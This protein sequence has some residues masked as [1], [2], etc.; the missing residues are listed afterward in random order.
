MGAPEIWCDTRQQKGK[1]V[2]VDGWFEKHGVPHS[3]RKL[4]FGDYM[5]EGSNISI[6]TKQSMD[7]LAGN[8]GKDHARFVRECE[9]A[10]NAGYRLIILVERKPKLNSPIEL[11][12]W[13]PVAC[14]MCRACN[15]LESKGCL[16]HRSKPMQGSTALKIMQ[17]IERK[18]GTR[19]EFCTRNDT[20][21]RICEL[22]GIDYD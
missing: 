8:L 14:H 16:K 6:D 15:P 1:H 17:T 2:N 20:A 4:D 21:Q 12:K 19:F 3:Y 18:Y 7:E 10:A 13:T 5:R 9:R 22:L 11:A